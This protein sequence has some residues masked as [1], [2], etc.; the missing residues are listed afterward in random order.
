MSNPLP[1]VR[2]APR[3]RLGMLLVI[4]GLA[5]AFAHG[6]A[7]ASDPIS[8][9]VSAGTLHTCGLHSDGTVACWGYNYSGQAA[10][11]TGSFGAVSAGYN[12]SCGVHSDGQSRV[13]E[14]TNTDRRAR[15]P[16]AS[17]P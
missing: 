8:P 1:H 16:A 15:P 10:P 5:I 11:P 14:V 4:V 12:H 9:A 17:S 7:V 13:G 6:S 2:R 3:Q